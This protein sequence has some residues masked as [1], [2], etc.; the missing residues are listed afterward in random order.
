[1]Q[2]SPGQWPRPFAMHNRS[3]GLF[4]SRLSL[5]HRLRFPNRGQDAEP[6]GIAV[7]RVEAAR[8]ALCADI[9]GFSLNAAVRGEAFRR[10]E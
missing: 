5:P 2:A 4:E 9:D 6:E 10:S 3:T 8:Q 7:A 1:L